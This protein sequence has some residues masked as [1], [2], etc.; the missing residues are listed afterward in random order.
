MAIGTPQPTVGGIVAPQGRDIIFFAEGEARGRLINVAARCI[1]V[2]LRPVRTDKRLVAASS[3]MVSKPEGIDVCIVKAS[4]RR[5]LGH[6]RN[7]NLTAFAILRCTSLQFGVFR[8]GLLE[9]GD[10]GVGVFPESEEIVVGSAGFGGV[11]LHG[12]SATELKMGKRTDR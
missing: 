2:G 6:R 10:V 7:V 11:A 4:A 9:H 3:R 5:R 12:V 1:A 8:F